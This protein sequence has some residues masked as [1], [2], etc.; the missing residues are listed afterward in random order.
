MVKAVSIATATATLNRRPAPAPSPAPILAMTKENSPIW[1]RLMPACTAVRTGCPER[2]D[3][4]VTPTDLPT[5]T[6]S[7]K[8]E[9]EGPV[10]Q[11][12]RGVEEH[13]D[14]HEE[15]AGEHVP[16][17]LHQ[18]LDVTGDAGLGDEGARQEGTERHREAL[19]LGEERQ[20]EAEPDAGD[21]QCLLAAQGHDGAEEPG[22]HQ[23]AETEQCRHHQH[24]A[25]P[26]WPSGRC[27]VSPVPGGERRE[28]G[29]HQDRHQ[30]LGDQDAE[31]E[32]A[33]ALLDAEVLEG[34]RDDHGGRDRHQGTGEQ[35][36]AGAEPEERGDLEAEAEGEAHLDQGDD[37]GGGDDARP[38]RAG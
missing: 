9:D 14:R 34:V 18:R 11:R 30:V 32:L 20:R 13:A 6:T 27:S 37:A 12:A 19:G 8:R 24:E 28:R 10:A 17:R 33:G 29:Q 3:P 2:N 21:E 5:S 38:A 1:V 25:A 15:D 23:Q 4:T 36:G 26:R 22:H 7:V 16:E 35:A 31:D